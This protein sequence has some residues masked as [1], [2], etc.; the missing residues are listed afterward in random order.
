MRR[1]RTF[2]AIVALAIAALSSP[3][4]V[5]SQSDNSVQYPQNL[6]NQKSNFSRGAA[7]AM[8]EPFRGV[9]TS[10]GIVEGLF[11]I[12]NTGVSTASVRAAAE[13]FLATLDSGELSRVHFAIDDLE[14]RNWSNVD[15]GIFARHGISLE[16][17]RAP[18]K[19][20][21]WDL[22]RVALSAQG[23][24]Q[25]E[26]IMRTEQA[27]LEIN[28]EP[29]RYGEEKYYLTFMG[30]PSAD[31]PWGFQ[32]DGHHL[33]INYFVLGD[34]IVMTPAFYGG[35]PVLTET[36]KYA[37]NEILQAKQDLGLA[38][39]QSLDS[40]QQARAT[41]KRIKT[42]NDNKAEANKDNLT[43]DYEGIVGSDLNSAQKLRLLE[44]IRA[45]V[46]DLR[47]PH[48]E[49]TMDEIGQH[50]DETYFA[51]IGAAGDDSVFYYRIHSPVILIEF[52]HENPVG[53]RQKNTPGTPTRDHIHTVIRTPNGNDYGKDLLAQHLATHP[54]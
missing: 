44:V 49:I 24:D 23:L 13:N 45:F 46:G 54:H 12:R 1:I 21:A 53:T 2:S 48:A 39:M 50:I 10:A 30:I 38:L 15:V 52:D 18:Q 27:L 32:L 14:W 36:G 20:A 33:V 7:A 35:E 34:Q 8:S 42:G 16:E 51:W 28:G 29:I 26:K 17:M 43:L 3:T 40:G 41:I 25:T 4:V 22:L 19:T 9:A 11:E 47:D 5:L 6:L 31:E 37:G